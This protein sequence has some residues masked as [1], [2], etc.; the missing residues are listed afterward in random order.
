MKSYTKIWEKSLAMTD[1]KL[2]DKTL[3]SSPD[4]GGDRPKELRHVGA[5]K[6][7]DCILTEFDKQTLSLQPEK[8]NI[9]SITALD[10]PAAFID[11]LAPPYTNSERQCHYFQVESSDHVNDVHTLKEVNCP[12]WYWCSHAPYLGPMV[13]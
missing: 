4:A 3:Q 9:H 6:L 11:F 13:G 7:P 8:G 5:S 12:S 2:D 10:G 1:N